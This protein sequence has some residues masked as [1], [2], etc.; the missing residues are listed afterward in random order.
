MADL[1]AE[2]EIW[3]NLVRA[4]RALIKPSLNLVL[5]LYFIYMMYGTLGVRFFGGKISTANIPALQKTYDFIEPDWV[6]MNYNDFGS[7]VVSLFGMMALNDWE[8]ILKLYVAAV[9]IEYR[10]SITLFFISFLVISFYV[11]LNIFITFIINAYTEINDAIIL[12]KM[13]EK[14]VHDHKVLVEERL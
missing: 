11:I 9:G 14:R 13:V 10:I 2:L 6:Y 1:L 8:N 3:R 12:E 4:M 7:A 5:T